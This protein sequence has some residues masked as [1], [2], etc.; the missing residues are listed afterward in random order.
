MGTDSTSQRGRLFLIASLNDGDRAA[1]IP[2]N[3][4]GKE[5]FRLKGEKEVLFKE[6]ERIEISDG[7]ANI[8]A[9]LTKAYELLNEPAGAKGNPAD[10]RHGL[11]WLGSIFN[12]VP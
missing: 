10:Y 1:L 6:L 5:A 3:L 9:A 12:L 7:T 11:D 8:S 4:T 2:T